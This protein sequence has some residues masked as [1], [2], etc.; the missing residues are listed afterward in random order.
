MLLF[1][2]FLAA[3][4]SLF[5]SFEVSVAHP[6]AHW[7]A[8]ARDEDSIPG[9]EVVAKVR[10]DRLS[11]LGGVDFDIHGAFHFPSLTAALGKMINAMLSLRSQA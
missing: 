5:Q 6:D 9:G 3:I 8:M 1:E 7:V 10:L 2:E 11:E 4:V